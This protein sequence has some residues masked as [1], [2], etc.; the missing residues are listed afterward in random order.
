MLAKITRL[1]FTEFLRRYGI[2]VGLILMVV[3]TA[4]ASDIFLSQNNLINILRQVA[5]N[6]I[7]AVGMTMIIISGG[8]DLSV[9]SIVAVSGYMVAS[10]MHFGIVPALGL[11]L[12]VGALF[13]L[14]NGLLITKIGIP[15][16]VATLG[17]M[18]AGRG[19]VVVLTKGYP[20]TPAENATF[21][22]LGAG[23]VGPIPVPVI[24]CVV[25]FVVFG[26]IMKRTKIGRYIYAIG[27]NEEAATFSGVKVDKI[28]IMVYTLSG[29]LFAIA[30]I[31]LTSRLYS[32]GPLAGSGFE[33]DAIA[34][35]II[36]G[37]SMMGGEGALSRTVIGVLILGVL[38]NIFNLLGVPSDYQGILKGLIIV[39]AVGIDTY[40]R[41]NKK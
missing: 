40:S 31:V 41:K 25:I 7:L 34:A 32:S 20:I 21:K 37:T 5:V 14:I 33:M 4:S 9:G 16:F 10:T 17:T 28:R 22:A 24:I 6:G 30:G 8:I 18:V 1:S 11:G 27:S 15:P 12:L 36:G 3:I 23:Y 35:V 13:G 19:I 38:S 29:I 2:H 26:W 39:V